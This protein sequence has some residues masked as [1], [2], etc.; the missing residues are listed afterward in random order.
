V[1]QQPRRISWVRIAV[2]AVLGGALGL[3]IYYSPAFFDQEDRSPAPARLKTGGTSVAFVIVQNRWRTAYRK[4]TGI[5]VDYEST[6]STEGIQ[7]MI[8]RKYAIAFTHAPLS[9]EQRQ[10]A[11]AVG[12]AVV[13]LPVVLCAVVPVYHVKE[14]QDKPPLNLTGEVLADIF[15]GKIERWN[16]PA[17]KKLNEGVDLPDTKITV[18]HR[19][20][21]SGTTLIF[22]DYLAGASAAWRE[23]IGPAKSEVPWPVGVGKARNEGV[24]LHVQQTEGALGYVDLLH[25]VKDDLPHAAVQNKERTAFVHAEAENITAAAR[26]VPPDDATLR[27]TNRPGKDSYP[28]CGVIWAVCYQTQPT[29][30]RKKVVEFLQWVTHPGQEFAKNMAYARLPEELVALADERLKTIK[31]AP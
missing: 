31:S 9:D 19:E 10:K 5:D 14:L 24:A 22:T 6:G 25:A 28:I 20:D 17:L 11:Q 26:A 8:D 16:D 13:H 30:E 29:P 15:L 1:E 23:R 3:L 21:S 18:V 4:E 7:R 27:L 12:G 2:I